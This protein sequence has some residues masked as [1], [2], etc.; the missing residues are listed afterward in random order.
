[1][2]RS[3]KRKYGGGTNRRKTFFNNKRSKK[4][5][6]RLRG[7]FKFKRKKKSRNIYYLQIGGGKY[8]ELLFRINTENDI[9]NLTKIQ[10]QIVTRQKTT[11]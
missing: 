6:K 11:A 1:M 5:K 2:T 8:N 3:K 4:S 9:S 10:K 7:G